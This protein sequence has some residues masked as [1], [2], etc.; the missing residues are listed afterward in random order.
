MHTNDKNSSRVE[1]RSILEEL[2]KTNIKF[3]LVGGLAAVI[4]GAP[5]TTLDVDIVYDRSFENTAKLLTFLESIDAFYRHPND[6]VIQPN[7]D[8]FLTMGHRLFTIRLGPIDVLAFIEEDKKI[9]GSCYTHG[10]N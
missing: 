1:L 7:K 8:D 2:A 4:Q 9:R 10:R 5:V 3:I 6:K